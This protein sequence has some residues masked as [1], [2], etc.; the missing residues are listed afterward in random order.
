MVTIR[1]LRPS[2]CSPSTSAMAMARNTAQGRASP[3]IASVKPAGGHVNEPITLPKLG[4]HAGGVVES[5]TSR[6]SELAT[7]Q[8]AD[9]G[10]SRGPECA[11]SMR[12]CAKASI[13]IGEDN[14][15]L[16]SLIEQ[17][18]RAGGHTGKTSTTAPA[19]HCPATRGARDKRH[20]GGW[21][22]WR[23]LGRGWMRVA[24]AVP[25]L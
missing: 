4:P 16:R 7:T 25:R 2:L 11:Q 14:A 3:S 15:F 1:T 20:V 18:N 8:A 5:A 17:R 12:G 21:R 10:K 9:K 24:V 19:P 6:S 13:S 23:P 22:G